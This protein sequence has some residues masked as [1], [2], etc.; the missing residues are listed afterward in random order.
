[1]AFFELAGFMNTQAVYIF[2]A[3]SVLALHVLYVLFV[4]LG[5]LLVVAG[6]IRGWLWVRIRWFRLAHLL[7]IAVVVLQVWLGL[8][9][10]LTTLEMALR[11]RAGASVYGDSF[12]GHWLQ[13]LL[14]FDAPAWVFGMVYT[15]FALLVSISWFWVRP[16]PPR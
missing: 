13:T 1:M 8:V 6:G 10:P 2:L 7:A 3:D 5:L 12:I 14:Y 4:V 11:A 16:T 9:C 15:L